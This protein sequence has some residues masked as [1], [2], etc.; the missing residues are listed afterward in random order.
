[1]L[2]VT[3]HTSLKLPGRTANS[4]GRTSTG[5]SHSIHGIR[6]L[7]PT[8]T[9]VSGSTG[10]GPRLPAMRASRARGVAQKSHAGV[11]GEDPDGLETATAAARTGCRGPASFHN[12][13]WDVA[14]FLTLL[15]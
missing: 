4:Q 9:Y 10:R 8:L 5:E 14:T 3:P 13:L 7:L 2:W 6:T 12:V 15:L 1:M 11:R